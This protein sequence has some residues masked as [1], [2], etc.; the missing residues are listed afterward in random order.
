[1]GTSAMRLVSAIPFFFVLESVASELIT[2]VS[3]CPDGGTH[4]GLVQNVPVDGVALAATNGSTIYYTATSGTVD[5]TATTS[6]TIYAAGSPISVT[7]TT[8][9]CAIAQKVSN[10]STSTCRTFTVT[11][12]TLAAKADAPVFSQHGGV[13]KR[14]DKLLITT[15]TPN[16][17]LYWSAGVNYSAP[18]VCAWKSP[19]KEKL[20][21]NFASTT[22]S[23]VTISAFAAVAG[24]Q[25]SEVRMA[26]FQVQ[27]ADEDFSI[28]L[29]ASRVKFKESEL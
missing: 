15:G 9:I 12:G 13:V 26:V 3:F 1:M 4:V 21:V 29:G 17:D 22:S 8:T 7:T 25:H 16:A 11:N 5:T 28:G 14:G 10:S 20:I 23:M 6:G 18:N 19:A 27:N 24:R 2:P